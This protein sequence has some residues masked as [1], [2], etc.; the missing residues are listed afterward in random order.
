VQRVFLSDNFRRIIPWVLQG[1]RILSGISP[2]AHDYPQWGADYDILLR[3][4]CNVKSPVRS[5]M[6]DKRD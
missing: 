4:T 3:V 2:S 5:V 6:V 1:G